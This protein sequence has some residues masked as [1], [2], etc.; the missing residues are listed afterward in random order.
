MKTVRK[1]V[2]AFSGLFMVLA[3]V[4]IMAFCSIVAVAVTTDETQK[5]L[6]DTTNAIAK[7]AYE[8]TGENRLKW[9]IDL[10]KKG[11]ELPTKFDLQLLAESNGVKRPLIP[12]NLQVVNQ[13]DELVNLKVGDGETTTSIY[14]MEASTVGSVALTFETARD[15]DKLLVTPHLK[16]TEANTVDLLADATEMVFEIPVVEESADI[17]QTVE[18]TLEEAVVES[19][20]ASQEV[21]EETTT[22]SSEVE[23]TSDSSEV[24]AVT[25]TTEITNDTKVETSTT[26]EVVTEPE[27]ETGSTSSSKVEVTMSSDTAVKT[28]DSVE[29]F[30]DGGHEAVL[31]QGMLQIAGITPAAEEVNDPFKYYDTTNANGI[32]PKHDTNQYLPSA[33]TSDFVKNYNYGNATKSTAAQDNVSIFNISTGNLNFT[34][35]YHE[36]GSSET[37]RLNTKKTVSPTSDPNVFQVQ[38]DTIG[39]AIRP[40]PMVDIVLV[41]DKSSSMN[42]FT[43]KE[44]ASPTRWDQLRAAVTKFSNDMLGNQNTHDVQIGMAA[45]GS[46]QTG[47]GQNVVNNPYG[48]IASF[49]N[50]SS[51]MPESMTGFT[52]S[53]SVLQNHAMLNVAK[54]PSASGTP[55][56][57]GL[58]AGL[59]L[60]ST[61]GYGSRPG[62]KKVIITITDGIPTFYHKA[63]YFNGTTSLSNSLNKLTATTTSANSVLRLTALESRNND[64]YGGTGSS[65]SNY[66]TTNVQFINDRYNQFTGLNRYAVGFHT[67]DNANAVVSALGPEGA[68]KATD[69]DS[70]IKALTTAISELIATIYN[71]TIFDPMSDFVTLLKETVK[72]SALSLEEDKKLTEIQS[73]ADDYPQYAKD[74]KATVTD[75]QITLEDVNMGL[76]KS[77]SRQGYRLTYQV[78]LKEAFRDGTFYPTNKATYLLNGN[79][80]NKYYAVPS[81][82]VPLPKVNF[83]LTKI[84]GGTSTGLAGATFQLFDA[85]TGGN[86]KS[87][88]VISEDDGTLNFTNITPGTYWL[89]ETVTPEGFVTMDPIQITVNRNGNV[90]GDGITNGQIT[91]SLKR[92]DLT[93]YKKDSTGEALTGA[94]FKLK[95]SSSSSD[96]E[97]TTVGNVHTRE[98]LSPGSTYEVWE[99]GAPDGYEVLGKIGTIQIT[100]AGAI[101]FNPAAG[102][103]GSNFKVN[104][105]GA[106]IEISMDVNNV[107]KP[108]ELELI[109]RDAYDHGLFLQGATFTLYDKTPTDN[110]AVELAQASTGADG[111]GIFQKDGATYQLE[112]G[113]TYYFKETTPP[114]GYV[115]STS[116]YQVIVAED[117]S[118]TIKKDGSSFDEMERTLVSGTG[119]NRIELTIDNEPKVPLPATGG[120]GTMLFSLIGVLALLL[121]GGYFLLRRGQEA[122]SVKKIFK[123]FALLVLVLPT[124]SLNGTKAE[125]AEIEV[126]FALH[127]IAFPEGEMPEEIA[128][129]GDYEGVHHEL[130]M[131]YKGLNDV[132]FEAYDVT[133]QF[134]QMRNDGASVEE[135]QLALSQLEVEEL[136]EVV[137]TQTTTT[138]FEE[139]G[140][141]LFNLPAVDKEGRDAAYLFHEAAAP[142]TVTAPSKN[143]VVVLPVFNADEEQLSTIHLYP[144]NEEWIHEIPPFDKAV[145]DQVESYQFGDIINYELRTTVPHDIKKYTKF[146]VSDASD[147]GLVYQAGTLQVKAG[148]DMVT[149]LYDLEESESGFTVKFTDFEAMHQHVGKELIFSYQTQL[150]EVKT[151]TNLFK[152]QARLLTDFEDLTREVE[153]ETGGKRF[154]KVDLEDKDTLLVGAKFQVLNEQ[155]QYLSKIAGGYTWT[156]DEDDENLVVLESD[157]F[158]QFEV[159]GLRFGDYSLQEIAAP[160]GYQLSTTPVSFTISKGSY[161]AGD[162]GILQVVNLKTPER[163]ELPDTSGPEPTPTPETPATPTPTPTTT[164]PQA[165][166][167]SLPKTND[168]KNSSF[169]WVG[170]VLIAGVA[171]AFWRK[172]KNKKEEEE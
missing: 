117:G 83:T 2:F 156:D 95:T 166:R 42:Y 134:Y 40:I 33:T 71:G 109:K 90:S 142:E 150:V 30:D 76:D 23:V 82:K 14:E 61:E 39:D 161:T 163:P 67:D 105:K 102:I 63:D 170:T 59:K 45:F 148:D 107:L 35:G 41:L 119:N 12:E 48:E 110:T 104:R 93:L 91:N 6:F 8:E 114:D 146:Q 154:V 44:D 159:N 66:S 136:G 24:A 86:A 116:I 77:N 50:L 118:V 153:V 127:K 125:A 72:T 60:L 113:K 168:V 18:T 43:G 56:F 53:A 65:G 157:G 57:L 87:D 167:P 145:V 140:T 158:G 21:V 162:P 55:T 28:D 69:V 80:T 122:D 70:L 75:N 115:L 129:T 31:Y 89:R 85:E 123:F 126:T 103:T 26:E 3:Q 100:Q 27:S 4:F 15:F 22:S 74:I 131:D 130:L 106:Q 68:F 108:F 5:T 98:G 54:A 73:T 97:L 38:L 13:S 138:I 79:G 62:A 149:E 155:D 171:I 36:Y 120:P 112:A 58:D 137:D 143:L 172:S 32:Y 49:S 1:K 84:I 78:E 81:V 124:L 141:A 64:L 25:E 111:K 151:E 133:N 132:V 46:Y 16:T 52:R 128:N 169:I 96:I 139:D 165:V 144:K 160:E 152:N 9:T 164:T 20:E 29:N 10:E 99:T 121:S 147:P 94:T 92:I 34:N 19:T 7:M 135:A 37:G 11:S 88:A 47:S 101:V 17:L 51:G